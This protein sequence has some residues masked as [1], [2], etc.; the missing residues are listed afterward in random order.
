M[1]LDDEAGVPFEPD[2]IIETLAE[3][4]VKFVL[5]GGSDALLSTAAEPEWNVWCDRHAELAMSLLFQQPA[6]QGIA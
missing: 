2:R 6:L 4:H 1:T 3:H 5:V